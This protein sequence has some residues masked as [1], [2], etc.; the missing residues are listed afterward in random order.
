[1]TMRSTLPAAA[2]WLAAAAVFVAGAEQEPNPPVWPGT[3]R[4]FSPG[5][6]DIEAV[7]NAAYATNGGHQPPNHGQFSSA[8][9]AFLFKPGVYAA[10]VPVGYYTTVAGLGA[11]PLDVTFNGSMG[12]FCAETDYG[13][14]G[15]ALD[16][17]WRSAENFRQSTT[18]K[19]MGNAGMLWAVSQAS[20]LRRVV[21]DGDLSLYEY[22]PP[23][24]GAGYS[25]GGFLANSNISGSIYAGS[26]QQW[27]A[28]N[29]HL[30]W[31]KG[32]VWNFVFL[33]CD[34]DVYASGCTDTWT[35]GP[36]P[37]AV[38][39]VPVTPVV[40]E[41][42]FITIDGAGKYSL[43]VPHPRHN[44]S[45]AD[46]GVGRTVPFEQV[47]VANNATDTAAS[48][49]AKLAGGLDVV[50]APGVYQLDQALLLTK[51]GQV[52]LGLGM[53]TLV[54]AKGNAVVHVATAAA[55]ARVAGLLLQ[56]GHAPTATLL[57]WGD[58]PGDAGSAADPGVLSDVFGRVGGPDLP[59][60][61]PEVQVDVLVTINQGHVVVDNTWLWRADHDVAGLVSDRR[62]P[63]KN[64]MVVHGDD[65]TGLGVAIEHHLEDGLVWNGENGALFFYQAELPY[66]VTQADY[67]DAGFAGY[68]V[69][70][71]VTRHTAAGV[72]VYHFFRDYNVTVATGVVVPPA[73]EA[74][75]EN[76]LG[77]FLNGKGTMSHILNDR[78]AA[79]SPTQPSSAA[80]A[81][82]AYVCKD[83]P[84]PPPPPPPP[85]PH[86]WAYLACKGMSLK[87]WEKP[88]F[89]IGGTAMATYPG[90]R[91]CL[92][93]VG[94]CFEQEAGRCVGVTYDNSSATCTHYSAVNAVYTGTAADTAVVAAAP[95]LPP[96]RPGPAPGPAPGP[97]PPP[98]PPPPPP[99][100]PGPAPPPHPPSPSPP[101]APR[102]PP[103]PSPSPPSPPP[104]PTPS[105]KA[106]PPATA[107]QCQSER[108]PKSAPYECVAGSARGGCSASAKEWPGSPSCTSCVVISR[109]T[110][111]APA[112]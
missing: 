94:R 90:M 70:P 18:F 99:P 66:D 65:V 79:T 36:N 41:K 61:A 34:G 111:R 80:G 76:T 63:S 83:G 95:E 112:L 78:G 30:G 12:V 73:L 102:P 37:G 68:R 75:I 1:M 6:T 19:W 86:G 106:C 9:Y 69:A 64:G 32:G 14:T 77:I 20:P 108:C 42:P 96:V 16:T 45:G 3:V 81:H 97:S 13:M 26:Q 22:E 48:I 100:G 15:G 10:S 56:A 55:G 93:C 17:F 89:V 39:N 52:L 31:W 54:S 5:D 107:T 84:P 28:R 33:G 105:G 110:A 74:S 35:P 43:A 59:A 101:P 103:P 27:F 24:G 51:P 23:F 60:P 58:A 98:P 7:V 21:V 71:N 85:A 44:T 2:A 8:R 11:S 82:A 91:F 47:Y 72:G 57:R 92:D 25:S 109:C 29:S 38:T 104:P 87:V 49:N 40:A 53:A 50:L 67:G 46:W 88:G 62:N 4:V